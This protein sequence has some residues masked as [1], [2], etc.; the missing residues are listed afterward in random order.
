MDF[1]IYDNIFTYN[2]RNV[3][4]GNPNSRLEVNRIE[5]PENGSFW[6]FTDMDLQQNNVNIQKRYVHIHPGIG[7]T[8]SINFEKTPKEVKKGD[9]IFNPKT[10][11][12]EVRDSILPWKKPIFVKQ[13]LYYGSKF[14]TKKMAC[15]G[16]WLYNF[17]ND[18]MHFIIDYMPQKIKFHWEQDETEE[19]AEFEQMMRVEELEE[20]IKVAELQLEN[21]N[22]LNGLSRF[23][24]V[25][26][27]DRVS[28]P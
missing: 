16:Q 15:V 21:K 17:G 13:G 23:S 25:Q 18:T 9:L 12:L 28:D 2:K 10:K 11:S 20:K 4:N 22:K 5:L 19:V 8:N 1:F 3:F 6:F 27:V 14:P 7:K 24:N 26:S